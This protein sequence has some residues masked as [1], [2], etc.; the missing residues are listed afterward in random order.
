MQIDLFGAESVIAYIKLC[1][2]SKFTICNLNTNG[3]YIPAFDCNDSNSNDYA[4]SQFEKM[5]EIL[6]KNNCYKILCYNEIET[7]IDSK[8][9]EK[10]KKL[11]GKE[12]K[13]TMIFSLSQNNNNFAKTS[14]NDNTNTN[15][16][17]DLVSFRKEI[18]KEIA[19]QNEKNEM[20]AEIREMK[21]RFNALDE[22]EEEEEETGIAGIKADQLSQLM[23]LV[24]LF[25]TTPAPSLNGIDDNLTIDK[26]IQRENI[27]KALKILLSNDPELDTDLLKLAELSKSKPDTFKM[28]ISTLR[29]M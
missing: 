3:N 2:F 29:S 22:E 24:N 13:S 4:I 26:T 5:C 12:G 21:A 7:V 8:G 15:Q 20:L 10:P 6:N 16:G 23:G 18:I 19:E 11:K 9:N 28:L 27:N 25:K 1:N 17:V 14:G